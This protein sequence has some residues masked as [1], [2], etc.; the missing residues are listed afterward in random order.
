MTKKL[1]AYD[2]TEIF[3]IRLVGTRGVVLLLLGI[4]WIILGTGFL[5]SPMERFSRPGSG[6]ILDFLNRGPGIYIFASMWI[7]GGIFAIAAAAQRP[8][9]CE[10]GWGFVGLILPPLLWGAGYWWSWFINVFSGGEYGRENTYLAG[11]IYGAFT[12]LLMFLSKHLPDHP[13]GPCARRRGVI[14]SQ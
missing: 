11:L 13:E 10:D 3:F 6:G 9:T 12:L 8:K 5:V 14:D 4:M 1:N 7:V 2:R